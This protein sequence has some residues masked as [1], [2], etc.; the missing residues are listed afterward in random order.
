MA[1]PDDG[2]T[3]DDGKTKAHGSAPRL[4]HWWLI[5]ENGF[6]GGLIPLH[7]HGKKFK[8]PRFQHDASSLD[9]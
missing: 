3:L 7:G 2:D 1:V 6:S 5:P 4:Q 9:K 8:Q